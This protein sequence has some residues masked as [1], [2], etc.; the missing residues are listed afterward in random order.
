MSQLLKTTYNVLII[1]DHPAIVDGFKNALNFISAEDYSKQFEVFSASTSEMAYQ[2]L[3]KFPTKRLDLVIL[4]ISLPPCEKL[5]IDSGEDIGE[6]IRLQLPE[7]KI[8]VCTFHSDRFRLQKIIKRFHPEG[9]ICKQDMDTKDFSTAI[10]NVLLKGIYYSRS[11][12]DVLKQTAFIDI[13]L[14]KYDFLIL[15]E[16]SNGAKMK[17][18]VELLPFTKSAIDKRR[19]RLKRNLEVQGD[20][21]RDLVLNAK[22]RGLI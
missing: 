7:T 22:K 9:F 3:E 17:E 13:E 20:S 11:I 21:D 12:V 6:L 16:L 5:K 10:T 4:D 2:A 19:C 14:D 1:D 15:K 18:L 8:M